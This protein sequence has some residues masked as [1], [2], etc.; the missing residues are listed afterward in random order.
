MRSRLIVTGHPGLIKPPWEPPHV[1]TP[2]GIRGIVKSVELIDA[3]TGLIKRRL[4]EFE[5][6][7]TNAG[8]NGIGNGTRIDALAKWIAVGTDNTAPDVTDTALGSQLGG[9][10]EDN[11][12]FFDQQDAGPSYAY[13]S[14]VR[15]REI[16][17]NDC[18]GN[19]TELALF[20]AESGG[21]MWM[22]QLFLS[23][24]S[25]TTLTKTNNEILRIIYEWRVYLVLIPTTDALTI[26]SVAIDCDSR[27]LQGN[28]DDA[29]GSQGIVSRIGAWTTDERRSKAYETNTFPSIDGGLF[30]GT[31]SQATTV[32][33][34]AYGGGNFYR[35]QDLIWDPGAGNFGSGIGAVTLPYIGDFIGG[36]NAFG[37]T[38]TPKVA[39]SNLQRFT[40]RARVSFTRV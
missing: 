34:E 12:G 18:N 17:E 23:G 14:F 21:T 4:E 28:D 31:G 19:L 2:L 10:Y 6:L 29:W 8:L 11:G 15:T 5:N 9:R 16:P 36:S 38:F 39:K 35:D 24:G 7:I 3:K 22:R 30:S 33:T 20:S 32:T 40:F 37:T 25:P 26:N 27:A 1:T 13:W